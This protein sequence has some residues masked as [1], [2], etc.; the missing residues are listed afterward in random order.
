MIAAAA[1][2]AIETRIPKS[3][4][5]IYLLNRN[6]FTKRDVDNPLNHI[7][8]PA[9]PSEENPEDDCIVLLREQLCKSR[10]VNEVSRVYKYTQKWSMH[11]SAYYPP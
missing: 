3:L 9:P 6:K 1:I 5:T 11:R 2:T 8:P 7:I 10:I 4:I